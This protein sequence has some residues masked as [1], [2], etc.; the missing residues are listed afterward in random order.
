MFDI[1]KVECTVYNTCTV[2]KEV[3]YNEMPDLTNLSSPNEITCFV[4]HCF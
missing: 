4:L 1:T 2:D 3:G